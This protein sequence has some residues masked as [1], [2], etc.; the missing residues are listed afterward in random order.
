MEK[1]RDYIDRVMKADNPHELMSVY[2]TMLEN[3]DLEFR[4]DLD[5]VREMIE[6]PSISLEDKQRTLIKTIDKNQLYCNYSEIDDKNVRDLISD[7]DYA[8]NQ[9]FYSEGNE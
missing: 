1:S 2:E 5:T 7:S 6:D 8:F 3:V 4:A 9:S